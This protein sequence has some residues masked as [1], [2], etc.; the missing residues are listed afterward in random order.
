[1]NKRKLANDEMH[2]SNFLKR[3]KVAVEEPVKKNVIRY[4]LMPTLEHMAAVKIITTLWSRV[5]IQDEIIKLSTLSERYNYSSSMKKLCQGVKN[6]ILDMVLELSEFDAIRK[7]L[8]DVV[9]PIGQEI[10]D[11]MEYQDRR[12]FCDDQYPHMQHI[13]VNYLDSLVW[14]SRGLIDYKETA[15]A[16]L[17]KDELS[18]GYKYNIACHY[19]FEDEIKILAPK[20]LPDLATLSLESITTQPMLYFWITY[21]RENFVKLQE[22]LKKELSIY[23]EKYNDNY[24]VEEIKQ[25]LRGLEA[26]SKQ[27]Y[28]YYNKNHRTNYSMNEYL[29]QILICGTSDHSHVKNQVAIKYIWDRLNDAEKSR[30]I[31]TA[32][33]ASN[34]TDLQC[35]FLSQ[36][37]EKQQQE[38]F[39][40]NASNLLLSLLDNWLWNDYFIP[41]VRHSWNIIAGRDYFSVLKDIVHRIW[42]HYE[43]I[44]KCNRYK[45]IFTELWQLAPEH[46][47]EF[48]FQSN[49]GS[50]GRS[51]V[52]SLLHKKHLD[53]I[54]LILPNIH[55]IQ[56]K[57][58]IFS[59]IDSKCYHLI[60]DDQFDVLEMF[61]KNSLF[62]KEDID[63]FK[64]RLVKCRGRDIAVHFIQHKALNKVEHFVQ[65]AFKSEEEI[66]E[67]KQ[68]LA[69]TNICD[70]ILKTIVASNKADFEELENHFKW[71]T[72]DS[73]NRINDLKLGIPQQYYTIFELIEEDKYQLLEQVLNW[74]FL[75]DQQQVKQFKQ[76]FCQSHKAYDIVNLVVSL[77][78]QDN[79][80]QSLEK[81]VNWC[82]VSREELNKFKEFIL[83]PTKDTLGVCIKLLRWDMF[84]LADEVVNW[85]CD[86]SQIEISNFKNE[87]MLYDDIYYL[88]EGDDLQALKLY[89]TKIIEWFNPSI[90]TIAKFREKFINVAGSEHFLFVLDNYLQEQENNLY[91][92]IEHDVNHILQDLLLEVEN[93]DHSIINDH[94]NLTVSHMGVITEDMSVVL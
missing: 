65:W 2:S 34:N 81:F 79:Q 56:K 19:C 87:L 82:F 33:K 39:Q 70:N 26:K 72:S 9:D 6:K 21:I 77:V 55:D 50:D 20:V 15:R 60:I 25:D 57:K 22:E 32:V 23:N 28:Y 64:Q 24:T 44:E 16:L 86:A 17:A 93:K 40:D 52:L 78:E 36:M 69:Y 30:N 62:S 1:M 68:G 4:Y 80:L 73:Q 54:Q 14:A 94:D 92:N 85:G 12:V 38:I 66:S 84:K 59:S 75:N 61:I 7:I 42:E 89:A 48:V 41:T 3:A 83:R 91:Q 27:E 58:M 51:I 47:K 63:V 18:N 88:F 5:D 37:N 49:D 29:F 43:D 53:I 71:C 10:F 45:A 31:I 74:C 8:S 13:A 67:F 35:F 11:W 90:G 76:N 46:L